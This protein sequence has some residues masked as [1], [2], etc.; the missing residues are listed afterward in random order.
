[1]KKFFFGMFAVA[2]ALAVSAA[3][4]GTLRLAGDVGVLAEG[5][6]GGTI[7]VLIDLDSADTLQNGGL[8]N[9]KVLAGGSAIK[10]TGATMPNDGKWTSVTPFFT[11]NT[12]TFNSS[13]VL[14]PAFSPAGSQGNV[15]GRITYEVV[16]TGDVPLTW[17]IPEE[18]LVDGR[19]FGTDV[20]AN[21]TGTPNLI[22]VGGDVIIP[23]PATLAMVA[24]G[25]I[26]LVLRRRNG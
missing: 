20:T 24:T 22:S 8:A 9:L 6:T 14:T 15:I 12:A 26:G 5:V 10:F 13:S 11:D 25:M 21:Y 17:E 2:C 1:M 18:A 3:Q 16:G 19:D 7:E 4:A 23:E